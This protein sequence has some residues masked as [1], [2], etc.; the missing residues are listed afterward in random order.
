MVKAL[1][2]VD[3]GL[4][5]DRGAILDPLSEHGHA[6]EDVTHV[7]LIHHHPDHAVNTAPFPNAEMVDAWARYVG[8]QWLDH[9]G[10]GYRVSASVWLMLTPGHTSEDLSVIV[11]TAD[12]VVACTHAWWHADRTT[13]DPLAE[14]QAA[15]EVSGRRILATVDR[16]VP[17]HGEPFETGRSG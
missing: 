9:S 13:V 1:I 12:A 6:P 10:D 11:E 4:V 5:A 7:I 17:G 2:V 15:L 8:D 3:P 14:D 16:V